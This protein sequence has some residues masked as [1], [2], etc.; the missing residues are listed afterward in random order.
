MASNCDHINI[1]EKSLDMLKI[2]CLPVLLINGSSSSLTLSPFNLL[3]RW[4]ASVS[5][6]GVGVKTAKQCY[7]T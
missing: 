2:S 1:F 3:F 5:W 4:I 7:I 6:I